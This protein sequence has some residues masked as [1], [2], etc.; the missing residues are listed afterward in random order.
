MLVSLGISDA[1]F[2]VY[3][4]KHNAERKSIK[5][6]GDYEMKQTKRILTLTFFST[7]LLVSA[8]AVAASAALPYGYLDS[9][10]EMDADGKK[11]LTEKLKNLYDE[12]GVS[13]ILV[14][15]NGLDKPVDEFVFDFFDQNV[16]VVPSRKRGLVFA[17]DLKA[18][19][20][21]GAP[22]PANDELIIEAYNGDVIAQAALASFVTGNSPSRAFIEMTEIFTERAAEILGGGTPSVSFTPTEAME[23]LKKAVEKTMPNG[24]YLDDDDY[25]TRDE[26][27][28]RRDDDIYLLGKSNEMEDG[29]VAYCFDF[30][31]FRLF[32]GRAVAIS[33]GTV[34]FDTDDSYKGYAQFFP[35]EI[36]DR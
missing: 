8:L 27:F 23:Y 32:S 34:V 10:G 17:F 15:T 9:A 29:V 28:E 3:T 7:L 25:E 2:D 11:E 6:R 20:F 12:Y 4:L 36:R 22:F 33:D 13:V 31:A 19:Q 26:G 21:Y 1:P 18:G 35:F 24:Y 14:L 30:A 5:Q 16:A